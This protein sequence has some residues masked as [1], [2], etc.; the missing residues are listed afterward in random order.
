MDQKQYVLIFSTAYLP[1]LGGAELAVRDITDRVHDF[2]FILITARM[3]RDLSRRERIG[4]IDIYRVGVGTPFFDKIFSPILAAWLV[5]K[6]TRHVHACLFWSVMVSYT[7][8]TPVFLKMLGLYKNIPLLVTLQE[9]DSEKHI[10]EGRFGLIAY[11]WR[12][13]LQYADHVQVISKYLEKLARDFGYR[14]PVS[15]VPNGV[16]TKKFQIEKKNEKKVII[17]ISRL[18]E[19]NGLDVLIKAF[20]EVCK[21]FPDAALHIVGDGRL[22]GELEALVDMLGIRSKT[23]F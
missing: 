2:T 6:I 9:G 13:S 19:K 16:N 22:R 14:G 8:I 10:F 11:W 3:R 7:T 20:A 18:V 4:N 21:K 17:T 1:L 5:F 15:V 12:A 23:I